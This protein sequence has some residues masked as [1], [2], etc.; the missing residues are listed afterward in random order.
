MNSACVDRHHVLQ[1]LPSLV[2]CANKKEEKKTGCPCWPSPR[3]S[4]KP[5]RRFPSDKHLVSSCRVNLIWTDLRLHC[6]EP[7]DEVG[8]FLEKCGAGRPVF[9]GNPT[10]SPTREFHPIL[11]NTPR[12]AKRN[13][14]S[15]RT[16]Q[17]LIFPACVALS[18][19]TQQP[20][21]RRHPT[22]PTPTTTSHTCARSRP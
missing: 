4:A 14:S 5:S 22:D 15:L 20:P 10:A 16:G 8:R 6:F 13:V 3:R 7:Y 17:L 21:N 9:L 2:P 12:P 11:T 19:L 1:H 18:A